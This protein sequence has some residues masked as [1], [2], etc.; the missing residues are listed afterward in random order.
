[1]QASLGSVRLACVKHAASVHPEPGSN[2]RLKCPKLSR[3]FLWLVSFFYL[4]WFFKNSSFRTLSENFSLTPPRFPS[5]LSPELS[6]L[7][8]CFFVNV[9]LSAPYRATLLDYHR[10]D[11]LSTTFLKNFQTFLFFSKSSCFQGVYVN[12]LSVLCKSALK[13]E[14]AVP[15]IR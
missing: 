8:Y 14:K 2:S 12:L 1:M 10:Q 5:A 3:S 7:H 9:L 15:Y 11:I 6:G 13:M 4:V